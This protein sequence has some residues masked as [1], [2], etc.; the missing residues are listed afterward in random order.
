MF[1]F[2][3]KYWENEDFRRQIRK[4][5]KS[6]ISDSKMLKNGEPVALNWKTA[7]TINCYAYSLGIMHNRDRK[8][9]Y[10]PGFTEK[11]K[12]D[13][14]IAEDL[15]KGIEADLK[16]LEIS[17]RFIE[18]FDKFDLLENEY[19]VKV[20]IAPP[21]KMLDGGDFHLIRQDKETG[22]WFH[23]MGWHRQ[24][25]IIDVKPEMGKDYM[26]EGPKSIISRDEDCNTPII[27]NPICYFAITQ[28]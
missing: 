20:F 22:R 11:N 14:T 8:G 16:N 24:P 5:Q 23:K 25:E 7:E 13:V 21:T 9:M 4:I 19:L 1:R 28:K 12:Y 17:Y 10:I 18:L 6:I 3:N 27:Y 2:W 15:I 26:K